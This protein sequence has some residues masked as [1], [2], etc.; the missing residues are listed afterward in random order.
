[1]RWL[2]FSLFLLSGSHGYGTTLYV[3]EHGNNKSSG[4]ST[5][6]GTS[7][8]PLADIGEAIKR[9]SQYYD[10]KAPA[11]VS[12]AVMDGVYRVSAP[13]RI[14]PNASGSP[15]PPLRIYAINAGAVRISG[16]KELTQ[17]R[18]LRSGELTDVP[19][20]S[21]S[22]IRV[23]DFSASPSG[24]HDLEAHGWNN[25]A[26]V[27]NTDLYFKGTRMR[28]ARWPR[29]DYATITSANAGEPDTV[30]VT[31][32][33]PGRFTSEI[34]LFAAGY[35]SYDWAME[36][37]PVVAANSSGSRIVLGAA[38]S[39]PTQIGGRF[40]L[41]NVPSQLTAP[42]DW[43][44]DVKGRRILFWPPSNDMSGTEIS[45]AESLMTLDGASDVELNGLNFELSRG[46]AIVVTN[47][48]NIRV[49]NS[50]IHN[51]G[52]RAIDATGNRIQV[53][54][55]SIHDVGDGGVYITAGDRTSL[56][57]GE[58]TVSGNDI[59]NYSLWNYTYRPGIQLS[60][61]GNVA[62]ENR[63]HDAPHMAVKLEGNDHTLASNEIYNVV[64]DSSD[65]GAVYMGQD[66]TQRGNVIRDNH[67]HD[68]GTPSRD[69]RGVYLDDQISGTYVLANEFVRVTHAVFVGG[70]RDNVI[71]DNVFIDSNPAIEI[72]D[73]GL[74][75]QAATV[76]DP[77]GPFMRGLEAVPYTG[78]V[79]SKYLHLKD[80]LIDNV[81][82]PKY[83]VFQNN[84]MVRSGCP[85]F[86][87][88]N[89]CTN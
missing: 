88:G 53:T 40:F 34:T 85:E 12:I 48:D 38:P 80:I 76:R 62:S 7:S 5:A 6:L 23:F 58:S 35:F 29:T 61:V 1:M 24:L 57:P 14:A 68:I 78:S 33:P 87:S 39:I 26:T 28:L 59:Y 69:V 77:D 71:S 4:L 3:A 54:N 45:N 64:Q 86:A 65:A 52:G 27:A 17:S 56:A 83:N 42:G 2:M 63:I 72:D 60:G 21:R 51:I 82:A 74:T 22:A 79:Y 16:G 37:L 15:L 67:L 25:P 55:C 46:P 30:Y 43:L 36:A 32:T 84:T 13:I 31:P 81:G 47:S 75:W 8:G 49:V 44:L 11:T 70:G 9:A 20:A 73:R 41:E 19:P 10:S 89:T 18:A 50:T 66:W